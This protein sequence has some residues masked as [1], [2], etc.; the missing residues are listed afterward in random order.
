MRFSR[1]ILGTPVVHTKS[2]RELGKIREWLLDSRGEAFVG[3]VAEGSGWITQR[4]VFPY[5]DILRLGRD[6]VL[7]ASDGHH[8]T[9]DPPL[10]DGDQT[11]RIVGKRVLSA[12]GQEL[13]VI[14]DVLFEESSGRIAGW[15][16]SLGLIDDILY[17][18]EI[19]EL[20]ESVL[21]GDDVL[22]VGG[23]GQADEME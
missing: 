20:P 9:G 3:F 18:R 16:L 13:G 19:H 23:P 11:C 21:I 6:A 14:E 2:G 12:D 7:V 1:E 4:R 17:G 8:P 15:R 10:L 22:I 5:G